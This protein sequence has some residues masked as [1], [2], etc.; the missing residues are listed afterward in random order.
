MTKRSQL[1]SKFIDLNV[2]DMP[3]VQTMD[4]DD[5]ETM[6]DQLQDAQDAGRLDLETDQGIEELQRIVDPFI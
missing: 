2:G 3:E 4:L 1:I 6:I 5:L